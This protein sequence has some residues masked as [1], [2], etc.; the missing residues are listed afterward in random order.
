MFELEC[1]NINDTLT[2]TNEYIYIST[3]YIEIIIYIITYIFGTI[4]NLF[5]IV[6]ILRYNVLQ[7]STNIYLFNL[8]L[9]DLL[10]IQNIPFNLI[11]IIK[12]EWIFN[13]IICKLNWLLTSINQYTQ[14]YLLILLGLDRYISICCS[15]N[16]NSNKLIKL[17]NKKYIFI[18]LLIMYSISF[19]L[20]YPI[21]YYSDIN[22]VY[23]E[24]YITGL[25]VTKQDCILKWSNINELNINKTAEY[26]ISYSII[27][28]FLV[29][30][31]F[32]IYFYVSILK[33][34]YQNNNNNNCLI[35]NNLIKK[36]KLKQKRKLTVIVL[37]I[38]TLFIIIKLPFWLNQVLI[39]IFIDP[40]NN[41][42]VLYFM[43]SLLQLLIYI[44]SAINPYL[45]AFLSKNFQNNFRFFINCYNYNYNTSD[46]NNRRRTRFNRNTRV[47]L[48]N[49]GFN[50][51]NLKNLK[52][53]K[54]YNTRLE[55]LT[56]KLQV[57]H[58]L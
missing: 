36:R 22:Y 6:V 53:R 10:Y 21:I 20:M 14:V 17:N 19:I 56:D 2:R 1:Y 13:L 34:F 38:I 44:N 4:G 40:N 43:S 48:M 45:Y 30:L 42:N 8:S 15:Y 47:N 57:T 50:R 35:N 26:Y 55:S 23:G 49:N 37:I 9:V 7:V 12:C 5:V 54:I 33:Y 29:P 39:L 32:I 58:N 11:T 25:N 52:E 24:D 31:F 16:N 46:N 41:N 18:L 28:C 3:K 27:T 51:F